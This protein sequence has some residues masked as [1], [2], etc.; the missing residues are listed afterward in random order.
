VNRTHQIEEQET[1]ALNA[2]PTSQMK[3][4]LR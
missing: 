3:G 4:L 1:E 2:L